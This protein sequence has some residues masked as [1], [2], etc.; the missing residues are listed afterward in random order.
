MRN[1]IV[2]NIESLEAGKW[3]VA[4]NDLGEDEAVQVLRGIGGLV[5]LRVTESNQRPINQLKNY[6]PLDLEAAG[7]APARNSAV[8]N[9][10]ICLFTDGDQ[11]CCVW[12]DFINLH[13]SPV[14]FGSTMRAATDSLLE[15]L[16][17]RRTEAA[18]RATVIVE[19]GR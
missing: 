1:Y 16:P 5:A 2:E 4:T 17:S 15:K 13:E 3:Y 11:W 9:H 18:A 12:G 7:S 6:R 8:P 19:A 14:G 10:A